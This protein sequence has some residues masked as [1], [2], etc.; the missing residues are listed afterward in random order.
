MN[1]LILIQALLAFLIGM[2]SLFTIYK[3]LG[4][5]LK[6]QFEVTELNLALSI[7][8][9]GILLSTANLLSTIVSPAMNALRYLTQDAISVMT[10]ASSGVYI[11]SFLIIGL[12]SSLLVTWGGV[13]LFFQI[14]KVDEIEELKKDNI[15]TALITAAFVLGIS[16]VLRDYVGHLCESLVPYPNVLNIR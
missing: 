1:I 16:I 6:K 3:V 8:Q 7:F 13:A 15:P 12:V 10:I 4:A 5:Y 14:T 9:T 11:I 2:A